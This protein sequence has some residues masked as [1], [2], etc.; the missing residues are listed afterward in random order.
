[1]SAVVTILLLL[2]TEELARELDDVIVVDARP[3]AAYE[4]GHIPGARHLAAGDLSA[5][6]G[7]VTGLLKPVDALAPLI[8]EAG[9]EQGVPIVVYSAMDEP[10]EVK[11]AAR[12]FWALSYLGF[13]QVSV[14][15]GGYAKWQ[16]EGR[17][18]ET[19]APAPK[20]DPAGEIVLRPQEE[21][22]ATRGEVLELMRAGEGI[23]A[24][25]R[26]PAEYTGLDKAHYVK[27][28]GHIPGAY[29]VPVEDLVDAHEAGDKVFYTFKT[30]DALT[31]ALAG[32]KDAPVISYCNTGRSGSVGYFAYRL[33]GYEEVS[34]YDGA[35][36]EWGNHPGLRVQEAPAP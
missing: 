10:Y 12:V 22:H 23:L 30:G 34:L 33:A 36:A 15:D 32:E 17:P 6:Q 1:M 5:T 9:L 31:Q 25:M 29:S 35:M 11:D 2:S 18:T 27:Q 14:L 26:P 16:A 28:S 19:G 13:D 3:I 4:A 7:G 20:A 8:S 21:R 24:D